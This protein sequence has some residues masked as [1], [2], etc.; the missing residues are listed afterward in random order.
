MQA[1]MEG[2]TS[3]VE[4][5]AGYYR[6]QEPDFLNLCAV[7]HGVAPVALDKSFTYCELGC[8]QGMTALIM[9]ANYPKGQF[10]AID[11]NPAHIARA[12]RL[13]EEAGL[14]NITFLE[15][16][17]ADVDQDKHL[18]PECDFIVLHGIFTWVSD[19]N[20]QHII[21]I[22]T[23]KLKSGGIVYNSY[24]AKPGWSIG[25]PIQKLVYEASKLYPGNSIAKLSQAVSLLKDLEA[26]SPRFF[27]INK[28]V[29]KSRL[30]LL[31]SNDKNYLV[32]EYF[33]DGWKAFYFTEIAAY[34]AQAKLE[35]VGEASASASYSKLL[36]PQK[37]KE[38]LDKIPDRNVSELFK[39]TISNTMFR[40]DMY[41][42]GISGYFNAHEQS[43]W[44]EETHWFL[45][46]RLDLSK[47]EFKFR[48]Q[49]VGEVKG[50]QETYCPL[51]ELLMVQP[52]TFTKL[53]EASGLPVQDLVQALMFLYQD[54]I[55]GMRHG[56]DTDSTHLLN[57]VLVKQLLNAQR[58]GH[59]ALPKVH[60][61]IFLSVTD[62]LF[63]RAAWA[64]N[65]IDNPED[66]V[67]H[68]AMGLEARGLHL[69][70]EGIKLTG[71]ALRQRLRVL[72][73]RWREAA[74]PVLRDGGAFG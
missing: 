74:L 35:F 28:D 2:Y 13:A 47:A 37:S 71:A 39:D 9:A 17:F 53:R 3:D 11:F 22:C 73:Q 62:L 68:A 69:M 64:I 49:S 59:L 60:S 46:K 33:H 4:Y 58:G 65:E 72:E 54:D 43:A 36:F 10:Y 19:E 38:L 67:E 63:C 15:R 50:K 31:S 21:N 41:M 30:E 48:L 8:G 45:R 55:V 18:L 6:E 24:N 27:A 51:I 56:A 70:N 26:T 23:Q 29:V 20:R 7:M 25:E 57:Q 14:T 42:R 61:A 5:V 16:S 66:L 40:K 52:C 32:H 44:L 12:R 1:W 34:M